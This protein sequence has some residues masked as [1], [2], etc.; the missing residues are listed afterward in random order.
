MAGRVVLVTGANGGIGYQ[1]ALQLAKDGASVII[2]AR[3]PLRTEAAVETIKT[4]TGN[5]KVIGIELDLASL[6]STHACAVRLREAL[7]GWQQQ[8]QL[9]G[10]VLN[11]GISNERL[12]YSP[13]GIEATWAVN[14][15]GTSP[16]Q[17]SS[18]Q[19]HTPCGA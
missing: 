11:A 16:Q 2:A 7:S 19:Q 17:C 3:D 14:H 9:H 1:T 6:D 15:L 12:E 5:A 4:S 13:H 8:Q 10:V 18:L